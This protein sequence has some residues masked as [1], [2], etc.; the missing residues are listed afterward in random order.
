MSRLFFIFFILVLEAIGHGQEITP[1]IANPNANL[2][3]GMVGNFIGHAGTNLPDPGNKFDFS[4]GELN[5]LTSID[6][7]ANGTFVL[8]F[9]SQG[10]AEVE[11]AYVTTTSLPWTLQV[12]AGK[13]HTHFGKL[14]KLHPDGFPFVDLP[15]MLSHL[16]N[17]D[18]WIDSG[19]SLSGLIP[20]R[21]SQFLELDFQVLNGNVGGSFNNGQTRDLAYLVHLDSFQ[22]LSES[23]SLDWGISGATGVNDPAGQYRT[24]LEGLD[25]SLKW[26]PPIRSTYQSFSWLTEFFASQRESLITT[27]DSKGLYSFAEYQLALRWFAGA[28]YDY[29]EQIM[30]SS[31]FEN[32]ESVILTFKP[33][34]FQS[35]RTQYKHTYRSYDQASHEILLQW[36]FLIGA[37]PAHSF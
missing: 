10:G 22:D 28:R 8:T 12:K 1:M 24:A 27:V 4:E 34:E 33:T 32:A 11:E 5:L 9:P 23:T 35:I 15:L 30:D 37:H 16:F 17:K 25:F 20:N 13:F 18:Q 6:P 19:V 31:Q 26:K 7:Y 14:N 2:K 36:L 29:A 21:W 3:I